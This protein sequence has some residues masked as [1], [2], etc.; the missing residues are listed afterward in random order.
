MPRRPSLD[1]LERDARAA[2]LYRRGLTYRQIAAEVGFRSPQSVGDAIRR[3]AR[4]SARD[5][6]AQAEATALMLERLQDYRRLMWRVATSRH[7]VTTQAGKLAT[8][9]D[10]Q[11][12][13]DDGPVCHAVDR[14]LKCDQEEARLRDLYPAAKSR[15]E[16]ITEDAID[17]ELGELARQ[18]AVNDARTAA[19]DTG[20]A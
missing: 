18:I 10:G 5:P 6:L 17:A 2:D 16:V 11:P 12:L 4:E 1:V 20:P 15:V 14:L 19:A 7:Y 8:G 3:H 9:P 13:V